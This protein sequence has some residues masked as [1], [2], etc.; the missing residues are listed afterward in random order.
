VRY[1]DRV[2]WSAILL[3]K[4]SSQAWRNPSGNITGFTSFEFAISEKWLELIKEIAPELGHVAFIFNP[5]AAPFAGK[6]VES[7]ERVAR[8]LA[9]NLLVSPTRD[10]AEIDHAL[11][12]VSGEPKGGLIIN[13]DAFTAANRGL[14]ISLAARYHLPA[15]LV[16]Q[17]GHDD[18][19]RRCLPLEVKRTFAGRNAGA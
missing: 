16:A 3:D 11:A 5:E 12:A 13:P 6:F 17:S 7:M 8:S 4:A 15:M 10:A 9:I 1:T 2:H 19:G 18:G 14:I